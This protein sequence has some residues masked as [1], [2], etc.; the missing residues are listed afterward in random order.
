M[1]CMRRFLVLR[2]FLLVLGVMVMVMKDEGQWKQC[3]SLIVEPYVRVAERIW[4]KIDRMCE[5]GGGRK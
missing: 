4:R 1:R 5:G 2:R 3:A